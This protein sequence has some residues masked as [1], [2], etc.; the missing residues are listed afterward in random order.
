MLVL[1]LVLVLVH[2]VMALLVQVAQN[3]N[4]STSPPLLLLPCGVKRSEAAKLSWSRWYCG[5]ST[6]W[7]CRAM[8]TVASVGRGAQYGA[9]PPSR[10]VGQSSCVARPAGQHNSS[11]TRKSARDDFKV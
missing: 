2:K 8:E 4:S 6:A 5:E 11:P 10:R 9:A 1:V 3:G 7:Y